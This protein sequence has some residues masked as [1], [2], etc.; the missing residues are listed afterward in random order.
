MFAFILPRRDEEA[1]TEVLVVVVIALCGA[2]AALSVA[3]LRIRADVRELVDIHEVEEPETDGEPAV[4]PRQ[5]SVIRQQQARS[6]A[7]PPEIGY[8]AAPRTVA[9][10]VPVIT[11]LSE[12]TDALPSDLTAARVASV[13]LGRPLIKAA[14]FAYGVR[15]AL[16]QEHRIRMQVAFRSEL[17]Q[18]RKRRRSTVAASSTSESRP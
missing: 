17:R 11:Q 9:E 8:E 6:P 13:A 5:R 10:E 4:L 18:Q 12:T 3:V 15:R 16:D 1:M 2:V 14:A 7:H